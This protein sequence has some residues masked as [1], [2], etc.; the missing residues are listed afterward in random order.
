M[1]QNIGSKFSFT[2]RIEV[3]HFQIPNL[4]LVEL[5]QQGFHPRELRFAC[6]LNRSETDVYLGS[7]WIATGKH[8]QQQMLD[9]L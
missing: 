1:G 3:I 5:W 9:L 7:S 2:Q 6:Y 4:H 8:G